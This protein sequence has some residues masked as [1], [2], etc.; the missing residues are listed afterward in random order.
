MDTGLPKDAETAGVEGI[1]ASGEV[2]QQETSSDVVPH[3]HD[4]LKGVWERRL[5]LQK[6]RKSDQHFHSVNEASKPETEVT[7]QKPVSVNLLI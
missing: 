1:R 2:A 3:R 6:A 5:P 7:S 4:K